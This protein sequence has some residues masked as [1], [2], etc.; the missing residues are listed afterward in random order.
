M[1]GLYPVWSSTSGRCA[2]S[3]VTREDRSGALTEY[4]SFRTR[5]TPSRLA[6]A[7]LAAATPV[8][9]GPSS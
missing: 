6:S 9:Y 8:P 2:R 5:F 7:S 4:P 1:S 3:F